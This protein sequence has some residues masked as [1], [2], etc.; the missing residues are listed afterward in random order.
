VVRDALKGGAKWVQYREPDLSDREFYL[1][2]LAIRE[3]CTDVDAGLIINDRLDI[4]FLVRADGVH[5]GR[6]DLPVKVVKEFAGGE[7]MVGYS[8][9]TVEEAVTVAWEG[10][11]YITYSPMF[12]MEHKRSQH[13]PVGVEG[14][15][16]IV[17][18]VTIPVFLLGG[19][20]V[21]DLK[22]LK[23]LVKPLR[24]GS[25]SMISEA[26]NV[27]KRVEEVLGILTGRK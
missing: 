25:T 18:K 21:T 13:K 2:C 23:Q 4:A 10:A 17:K 12:P 19:I 27:T 3:L 20:R 26:E 8:A 14:A 15:R 6:N 22:D 24:V 5:L 1:E 11:D 9:H 16:E 7:F